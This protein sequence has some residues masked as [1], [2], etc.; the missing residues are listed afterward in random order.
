MLF[1]KKYSKK[2]VLKVILLAI[3]VGVGLYLAWQYFQKKE[4][5]LEKEIK[6][7]EISL[8]EAKRQSAPISSIYRYDSDKKNYVLE[9]GEGWHNSDFSLYIYDIDQNN[10]V[11]KE[12]YY[13]FYDNIASTI[14]KSGRRDCN[15]N[16]TV[17]V[18]EGQDCPS[19]GEG[20]CTLY[21]YAVDNFGNGAI[22]ENE[23]TAPPDFSTVTFNIDWSPPEVGEIYTAQNKEEGVIFLKENEPRVYFAEVS[24]KVEVRYCWLYVDGKAVK[25]MRIEPS[26]CKNGEKCLA[27]CKYNL[28]L[29]EN[30]RIWARCADHFDILEGYYLNMKAGKPREVKII[31]NHPPE[32][33]SCRVEP[34][35]GNVS[36]KFQFEV[37]AFD[38]DGDKLS[39]FWE[40]GDGETSNEKSPF[41][42][43][44]E[45]GIYKPKVIVSDGEK[46]AECSTA[47][48]SVG[49]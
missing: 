38:P 34:V 12:C 10:L 39:Y 2:Q 14:V 11:P 9:K 37:K 4:E 25:E 31:V 29:P 47:W 17:K 35:Q 13:F 28:G 3:L 5:A 20:A 1:F 22:D 7:K 45:R 42:Q 41:H 26:S 30:H 21:V 32:I 40:F 43:Y 49:E 8:V 33:S 6:P 48:V 19:E 16:F 18:G 15:A 46:E 44:N 36:D 24:D 23:N 27:S